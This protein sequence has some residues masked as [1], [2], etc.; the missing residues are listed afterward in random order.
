MAEAGRVTGRVKMWNA[1][2]GFGFIGSD[3]GGED[4]FIHVS[5]MQGLEPLKDDRVEFTPDKGRN[6]KLCARNVKIIGGPK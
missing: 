3:A 4:L 5:Q 1:R 2:R 6:G